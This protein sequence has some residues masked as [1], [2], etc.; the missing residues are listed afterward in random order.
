MNTYRQKRDAFYA[1]RFNAKKR[2]IQFLLTFDQWLKIW[3]DSGYFDKRGCRRGQYCMARFNDRGSYKTNNVKII[4]HTDNTSEWTRTDKTK[5]KM[6]KAAI[7]NKHGLGNR[8]NRTKR[9]HT[10]ETKRKMS[11]SGMGN[12]NNLGKKRTEETKRKMSR[13]MKLAWRWKKENAKW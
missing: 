4:L 5:E 11:L 10:D 8:G 12:T 2:D 7:G 9:K 1:C 6:R 3:E 13:S